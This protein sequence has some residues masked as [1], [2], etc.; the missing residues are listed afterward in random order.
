MGGYLLS[1]GWGVGVGA[2]VQKRVYSRVLFQNRL[3]KPDS[4]R[5]KMNRNFFNS[6]LEGAGSPPN[7]PPPTRRLCEPV[8]DLR[9]L[10]NSVEWEL[11]G[12]PE[13]CAGLS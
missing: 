6:A 10:G 5:K 2:D 11:P 8:A 9:D 12:G 7:P 1:E 13:A 4:P 3:L